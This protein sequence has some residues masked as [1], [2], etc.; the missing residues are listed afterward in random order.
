MANAD[1]ADEDEWRDVIALRRFHF[2]APD[3]GYVWP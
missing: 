3:L 1:T 2:D